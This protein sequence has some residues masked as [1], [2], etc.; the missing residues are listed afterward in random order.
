MVESAEIVRDGETFTARI[1]LFYVRG[2]FAIEVA[3]F[4]LSVALHVIVLT[5]AERSF[6]NFSK[7]LLY[8]AF[9][10]VIPIVGLAQ[11][12]NVW[13]REFRDR[14]RWLRITTLAFMI[15]GGAVA[16]VQVTFFSDG[17]ALESQPLFAT[18]TSLFFQSLPLCIP[19][20]LLFANPMK[21]LELVKRVRVSLIAFAICI[22][23]FIAARSGFFPPRER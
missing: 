11:E 8:C 19:Y 16:S 6:A 5:D 14:P 9:A 13:K 17:A 10:V 1:T 2:L 3:L 23:L 18:A 20:S 22:V 4:T 7:P 15:Y 21:G 12:R